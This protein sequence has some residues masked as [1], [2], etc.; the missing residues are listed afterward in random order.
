MHNVCVT[1][2]KRSGV[3]KQRKHEIPSNRRV[4]VRGEPLPLQGLW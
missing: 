3:P 4:P 2:K 1:S